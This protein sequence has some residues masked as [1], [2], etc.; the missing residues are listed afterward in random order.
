[1]PNS[2]GPSVSLINGLREIVED[3][4]LIICD[5]WGVMHDGI[6][7]H[8]DAVKAIEQARLNGIKTVFLSNAPRPRE[9]VRGFLKD[10]GLPETLSDYVVTSGGL[11]R[12]DVRENFAGKKLYHLGPDE[13]LN[14]VEGLPI[15]RVHAITDA[16]VVLATGLEHKDVEHHREMLEAAASMQIPF[17]CAN[18]DRLVH[19]GDYLHICAGALADVYEDVGGE[20]RWF[21]KPTA[22]SLQSCLKECGLSSDT[23]KDS[24]LMIGDGLQTDIAGAAAAGYQGLFVAGG[25]HRDEYPDFAMKAEGGSASVETFGKVFGVKKAVPHAVIKSL[26]W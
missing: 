20:V 16:D 7:I 26:K 5:L 1:M 15:E 12:D 8:E 17:L 3:C 25:I 6:R 9:H 18:P 21:G 23:P 4:S 11:A 22:I 19:V 13:D 14:T 24:I 10:I 2:L